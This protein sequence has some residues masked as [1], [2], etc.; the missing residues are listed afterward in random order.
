MGLE[1]TFFDERCAGFMSDDA[2]LRAMARFEA[3]LAVASSRNG[4]FSPED[5]AVIARVCET[6]VFDAADLARKARNAG[7]LAIP[8]VQALTAQVAAV[9]P[10]ASRWVHFGATSQDATDTA[11]VLCLRPAGERI[12][13]LAARTGDAAARLAGAHAGTPMAARTMLQPAAPI[14]FGWKAAVWLSQVVDAYPP[15]ADA[16]RQVQVLQFA[17][18]AGTLASFGGKARAV[19]E[20]LADELQLEPAPA[21]WHSARGRLA[22][23]GSEAAILSG[24]AAKMGRDI[25][26]LMQAEVAEVS[27]PAGAGRGGSSSLPHKRNPAL[28]LIAL[29]AA[30]RVPALAATLLGNLAPEHERGLGHWQSQLF[31][32]RTL[33]GECASA[34]AAMAEALEGL[35]VDAD[36]MRANLDATHGLVFSE[37]LSSTLARKVGKARAHAMT[38]KLCERAA[39][40]GKHLRDV[41]LSEKEARDALGEDALRGLFRYEAQFGDTPAA[42]TRVLDAWSAVRSGRSA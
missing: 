20:A 23:L 10:Q 33:L 42:I 14:P 34:L 2:F 28:S 32:L 27:E 24:A 35:K 36:A 41:A 37:A 39:T 15:F 12:L 3:A 4:L 22:R 29:E 19:A 38:E 25:S 21:A 16:L 1:H 18:P 17:G 7:A 9:S 8:F 26:L 40:E 6:A 5:A 11:L 13:E 31:T 30:Q